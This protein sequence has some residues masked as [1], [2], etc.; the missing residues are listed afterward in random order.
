MNIFEK[1]RNLLTSD[2]F[3]REDFEL[4]KL[5]NLEN[6][7]TNHFGLEHLLIKITK[8]FQTKEKIT[9][10]DIESNKTLL[11][12][13]EES[14]QSKVKEKKQKSPKKQKSKLPQN[15][16]I[17]SKNKSKRLSKSQKATLNRLKGNVEKTP[18]QKRAQKE[19]EARKSRLKSLPI[20]TKNSIWTVKKK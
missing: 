18:E 16:Q 9:I 15:L 8:E 3:S 17:S 13:T 12:F 11:N 2:N 7:R 5:E 4:F 1:L 6:G 19:N 20:T 14:N 10:R